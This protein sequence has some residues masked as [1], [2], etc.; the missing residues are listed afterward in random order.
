MRNLIVDFAIA[1]A[2]ASFF[3]GAIAPVGPGRNAKAYASVA[4]SKAL[5]P[6]R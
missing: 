3:L 4:L 6:A 5:Q 1:L 2:I